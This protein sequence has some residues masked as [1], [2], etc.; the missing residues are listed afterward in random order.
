MVVRPP[1]TGLKVALRKAS[2]LAAGTMTNT[3]KL[4]PDASALYETPNSFVVGFQ[5][6]PGSRPKPAETTTGA[7]TGV[8]S[9]A[10]ICT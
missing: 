10:T 8:A 7:P 2:G 3:E 4:P 9:G 1:A 6:T 5:A